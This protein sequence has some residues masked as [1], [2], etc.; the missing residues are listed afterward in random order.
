MSASELS[1]AVLRL[2]RRSEVRVGLSVKDPCD[3][4]SDNLDQFLHRMLLT[5]VKVDV[6]RV[7]KGQVPIPIHQHTS[8][9]EGRDNITHKYFNTSAY[10][11]LSESSIK[12]SF[13]VTV[14]LTF[15]IPAKPAGA[16]KYFWKLDTADA[17]LSRYLVSPVK[18]HA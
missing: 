7:I 15:Q 13:E 10:Q 8:G 3:E 17:A 12:L 9:K 16:A 11:K 5:L 4:V 14:S 18:R 1:A 6:R 2:G